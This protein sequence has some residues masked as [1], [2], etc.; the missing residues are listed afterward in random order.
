MGVG[1][2][3]NTFRGGYRQ[4]DSCDFTRSNCLIYI[5]S[6]GK[7]GEIIN[8]L[9]ENWNFHIVGIDTVSAFGECP[10]YE[11][12]KETTFTL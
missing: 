2:L 7:I 3:Q 9:G 11:L 5:K 10:G 6:R 12:R 8:K 4:C 1:T